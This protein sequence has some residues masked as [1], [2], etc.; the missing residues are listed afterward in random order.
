MLPL[1]E[2][3]R[4]TLLSL[5]RRR[6]EEGVCGVVAPKEVVGLSSALLESRGAF[7][8]LHRG[9]ELRGCIG[10]IQT[11]KPLYETVREC[12][13]AAALADPRFAPVTP[14]EVPS[15]HIE[16]SVLSTPLEI[17]PE[18]VVIGEHGLIITQGRRRGLLLPQVPVTWDWDRERFLQETCI[19]AGLPKDAWQKGA[20]IE[21]FTAE[22][23]EETSESSAASPS[24]SAI[25]HAATN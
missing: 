17:A 23:F 13:A 15:L 25:P 8:T 1:T 4:K 3:E 10:Y 18:Q 9:G 5:A 11:S 20:R 2:E 22:V 12:A 24:Q 7:V 19:K 16:I 14:D 6:L 21:A